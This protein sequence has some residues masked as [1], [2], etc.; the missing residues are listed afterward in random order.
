MNL[1]ALP[2]FSDNYIWMLDDGRTACVVDPGEAGPVER[3][4]DER[5]LALAAILVTHHHDDHTGGVDALR[6]RLQGPV[7][8][9]AR[10]RV[11]EPAVRLV[12]GERIEVLGVSFRVIDIPGHTAG[13][14]AYYAESVPGLG[15][16][17]GAPLLFSGDT[18]FSGGCGRLFEGTPAQMQ[19][20]L[21]RMAALP[22]DTLVC[23]GHE[24]TLSNLAFARA[25]EPGNGAVVDY[26]AWCQAQRSASR[27]TLP[28]SVAREREVNPFLRCGEPE[29]V[30][31][32]IA[33]GAAA[34]DAVSV[35]AALR[36]W[37]NDF[38]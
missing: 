22:G 17:A 19:A 28:S 4:L 14:I 2:A 26:T 18:L 38:R 3:A 25:V 24:Y 1:T 5:G 37:K 12:D 21:A 36:S 23:C 34:T 8:G 20:S 10:E 27:P 16:D 11:P 30:R 9:P 6:P 35:L 32:A 13:H 31:S 29:V 7:Y 33:R 15:G